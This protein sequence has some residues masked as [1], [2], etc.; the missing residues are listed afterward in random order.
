[1]IRKS[2]AQQL[3]TLEKRWQELQ[4]RA[5]AWP[6]VR[7]KL[8]TAFREV[9]QAIGAL[10]AARAEAVPGGQ[11]AP[12]GGAPGEPPPEAPARC[13]T[14]LSNIFNA[15]PDHL[16]VIDRDHNIVMSNWH[17]L[18]VPEE[19]QRGQSKCYRVYH[20][21]DR[22]CQDCHVLKVFAT[23]QP[24]KV[25][26]THELDGR[27]LEFSTFPILSESGQ[28]ILAAE[29]VRDITQ[30]HL[31]EEALRESEARFRT[32]IEDSP[33]SL[34]LT[35]VQGAVL[36]A[37][38]VAVQR[39]GKNLSEVTG[40]SLFE[41]IPAKVASQRRPFFEQAVATGRPVR[42]EDTR[43]D[44]HFEIH[45]HPILDADGKVL[46][47]SIMALDITDRKQAE[48]ALLESEER[49]KLLFEYAPD[50]YFLMDSEGNFLDAN[51]AAEKLTGYRQEEMIGQ[52]FQTLPL[53]DDGQKTL[54][55]ELLAQSVYGE[56][57]GPVDLTLSR[58]DG[59]EVII[60]VKGLPLEIKGKSLL[61]GIARDITARKRA[62]EA[63]RESEKRFRDITAYAAEWVWEV[64]A[65]GKYIYS[66]PVVEQLLGYQPEEVLDKHFYDFFIPEERE[67]LK[68]AALALF[69]AKQPL[70][71]FLNPS[72][73][74]N[75]QIVWL[76]TSGIPILDEQG[77]LR[78][79]RGADIDISKRR[80]A[81]ELSRN[82]IAKSP[83]GIYL[84]QNGKFKRVN[85]WFFTTTGYSED[86][87]LHLEP[88]DLVHPEDR[89]ATR[90]NAVKML[91]GLS[92]V[93]YEYRTITKGGETKWIMETLSS[94]QY[95][96]ERATLG[97]FMDI[98]ERKAL[99]QQLILA[100]KMEAVGRLAGG[101]AHDF[102]NL[103]MTITGY[104]EL[105]RAKV[106]KGDPLHE[107]LENM[108]KASDRAAAL[109]Q[110]LLTFSRRQIVEPQVVDLNRVVLD[111]E[112]MLRRLIGED[113]ELEITTDPG[114]VAVKADP[115]QLGQIIMNLVVNA[116]DAMPR[117]GGL[118]LKTAPVE[119]KGSRPTRFGPV[120]PG[121]YVML[122]V[123]DT[124][125][126]MDEAIQAQ[127]FEPFFTTKEPGKGTGL[128]LS[129]VYGI[130]RHS[131]GYIDL[132][133]KP[134]AG[135]T[136]TIYLP[137]LAAITAPPKKKIPLTA[138]FR[139][140]ETIL[141]V[142]DEDIL[143]TLLAKFLRLYGYMVLEARHGGE[144]LLLCER[145]PGPIHLMVTDVVMPQMSGRELADRLAPLRPAMKVVYMSGYTDD[146]MV[147]YDVG[148]LSVP[149]L[150]KP[151]KPIELVRQVHAILH[152]PGQP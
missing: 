106:L 98:T 16:T 25:E 149:F 21:R 70:R 75:G 108:L 23:G 81:E 71:N 90:E 67:E 95:H 47:L 102:N 110:Q 37:S 40:T 55:T 12:A 39:L 24:Q 50:A 143:R 17:G 122:M 28:V 11:E 133:S 152:P 32:L 87:F 34:F 91:K 151:F 132:T 101:V 148:D 19:V 29:H 83:V 69:A 64:D 4:E 120:P 20:G 123:R 134:G 89:E 48:A 2:L 36:A 131:E 15:I 111:L 3:D 84:I 141:V 99:E 103:L 136:F 63:L 137:R 150:Q 128:G 121:A 54:V 66:S 125:V 129:T 130:V 49:F 73:H 147:H 117:G 33:E 35:D 53:L 93:P 115:G 139:G 9:S 97:Y 27:V 140:E 65:Q 80:E 51:R 107:H 78:G 114:P 5:G 119:V 112:P 138:S 7:E 144:A 46:M 56:V 22:P 59:R 105:M 26:K 10:R 61:L 60:A 145:R 77:N 96:G 82:L 8:A 44:F 127:I 85:Q 62:E 58:K 124:G 94:I 92:S 41:H 52:N 79:Y 18:E 72:V 1:M 146:S 76:S 118:S 135:S 14:I 104:G 68:Q 109:T 57:V 142:E 116:R 42:F 86:E 30:R 38:R 43:D 126:G 113:L 88:L 74:K 13:E 45:V 6:E 31:A 100:Q